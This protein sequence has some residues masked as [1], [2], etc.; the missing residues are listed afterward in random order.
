MRTPIVAGRALS[1]ND[2]HDRR[3]VM[4]VSESVARH[5]W[6]SAA[7]AIGRRIGAG[8][9]QAGIEVVGVMADVHHDGVHR[10]AT[11][12]VAVPALGIENATYVVR[13]SRARLPDFLRQVREAIRSVDPNLS[14]ARVQ[15]L[16]ELYTRSMARTSMTLLLLATTGSM[17]LVLGLIGVVRHAFGLVAIGIAIGLAAA[18]A[19]TRLMAA[20]LFGVTPLDPATHASVAVSMALAAGV[21]SYISAM[22]GT[23][24]DPA[25]VLR[26]D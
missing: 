5:E 24:L 8:P 3:P 13:S 19:L 11:Q 16:G 15:T 2:L 12:A 6:G 22:R 26:G 20:Q 17:A 9:D 4:M 18:A 10:P 7:A 14:P 25:I 21:A 23:A 1:W